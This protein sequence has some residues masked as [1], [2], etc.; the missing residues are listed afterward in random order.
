M[1]RSIAF[2]K[3]LKA[4]NNRDWFHA[5]KEEYKA[6]REE[7]SSFI[8]GII[9]NLGTYD[10][11]LDGVEVKEVLF[12]IFRDIRFS[13]DKTPYKTHYSAFIAKGGRKGGKAGYYVHLSP[14]ECFIAAG[15]HT[16]GKDELQAIRQEIV[17][18]AERFNELINDLIK[19]GYALNEEDKLKTGPKGFP[20]D[21]DQIEYLKNRHFLLSVNFNRSDPLSPG[22]EDKICEK[23]RE[24]IP[25]TLFL[26]EAISYTGN[27]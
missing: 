7:F 15:I 18:S 1:Q 14:E 25:F 3:K 19:K 21:S 2:L 17:Y 16:P 27:E 26:N 5:N 12:R 22:F 8:T 20:K 4:N 24:L 13:K 9:R 6:S 23:F 10:P 11:S